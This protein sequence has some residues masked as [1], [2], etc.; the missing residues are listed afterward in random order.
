MVEKELL[1]NIITNH[2]VHTNKGI[3]KELRVPKT[4]AKSTAKTTVKAPAKNRK[5]KKRNDSD[6]ENNDEDYSG[7][8][9]VSTS[10][11]ERIEDIN[12]LP[13]FI[14]PITLMEVE[15]PAISPYGHVMGYDC[16]VR[17]LGV[18][19][20]CPMTKKTLTKR[21]LVVLTIDNIEEYRFIITNQ[22]TYRKFSVNVNIDFKYIFHL[23]GLCAA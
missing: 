18:K 2:R 16:W 6:I 5:R 12:P 11:E 3:P 21:D 10:K 7:N 23:L 9:S 15:K 14:D 22:G 19:N 1:G 17:C 13:G 8:F 20:L 4:T